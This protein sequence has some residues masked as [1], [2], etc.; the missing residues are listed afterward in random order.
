[1][2]N[3]IDKHYRRLAKSYD[4]FLYYSP[5]FVRALTRKMIEKL[6]LTADDT[7]VDVGCG[8]GMYSF[9]ILE[10]VPLEYPVTGVDPFAE[11][12]EQIPPQAPIVPIC[13]D[14]LTF[15]RRK[16]AYDKVL[17]KETIH[18]VDNQPE[19]FA[20]MYRNL[21]DGGILLLVHVPPEVQYPLFDAALARCLT[22]HA[23]PLELHR[24]LEESGFKVEHD[25]LDYQHSLPKE[26]YFAMVRGQYMSVL[27]SFSDREMEAG[28]LE[29]EEKYREQKV[30]QFVDHFDYLSAMK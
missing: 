4:E 26:H 28:L 10:Q 3:V 9:D 17:V 29:M 27:T 18:H 11:M 2:Q 19:F 1:V 5:E 25:T 30:L 23:D 20:N 22:W 14:A 15:S 7:L 6:R 24:M 21:P 13:E 12:I 8:T 16:A